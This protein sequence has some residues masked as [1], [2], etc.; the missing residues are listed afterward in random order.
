MEAQNI[1]IAV[2]VTEPPLRNVT[3]CLSPE[4]HG[5][6]T[7]IDGKPAPKDSIRFSNGRYEAYSEEIAQNMRGHVGNTAN[8]GSEFFEAPAQALR[9]GRAIEGDPAS[10]PDGGLTGEDRE[11]LEKLTRQSENNIPPP[12]VEGVVDLMK[13]IVARFMVSNFDTP[14]PTRKIPI[15]RGRLVEL[16]ELL[17]EQGIKAE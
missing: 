6:G 17:E 7:N 8:G 1:P 9:H 12:A 4:D 2:F 3:V 16:V 5:Y 10:I 11:M 13:W 15:I 14:S